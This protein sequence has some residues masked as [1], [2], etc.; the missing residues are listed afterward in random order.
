MKSWI[1]LCFQKLVDLFAV[2]V[3]GK[4]VGDR[5]CHMRLRKHFRVVGDN[6]A[7]VEL[8]GQ[9][10]SRLEHHARE[11]T[12]SLGVVNIEWHDPEIPQRQIREVSRTA[13]SANATVET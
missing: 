9:A 5:R 3:S 8:R 6:C 7:L 4:I 11:F 2:A 1:Q 13:Y 10:L 12:G